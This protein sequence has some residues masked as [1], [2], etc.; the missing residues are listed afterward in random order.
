MYDVQ[1]DVSYISNDIIFSIQYTIVL[2]YNMICIH[3]QDLETFVS[4]VYLMLPVPTTNCWHR[5]PLQSSWNY[6]HGFVEMARVNS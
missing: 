3:V 4:F 5:H 1:I 2:V 6:W